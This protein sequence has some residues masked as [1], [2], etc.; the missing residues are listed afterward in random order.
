VKLRNFLLTDLSHYGNQQFV[1][2][3]A[4]HPGVAVT[5]EPGNPAV[6]LAYLRAKIL[7]FNNQIIKKMKEYLSTTD[8]LVIIVTIIL[9]V[10]AL[11]NKG[12]THDM[13]L[14]AGVLLV[15]IKIIMMNYKNSVSSKKI[16]DELEEIKKALIDSK[17]Q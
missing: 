2:I 4:S 6:S 15:S 12:L 7:N 16:M 13:L 10:L 17:N 8:L 11:F 5:L 14:E 9:F 3:C 1:V